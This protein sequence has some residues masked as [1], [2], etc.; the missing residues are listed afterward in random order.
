MEYKINYKRAYFKLFL[1]LLLL[2][3]SIGV[4]FY[5]KDP[6]KAGLI[7]F[8]LVVLMLVLTIPTFSVLKLT[9]IKD[10]I[11]MNVNYSDENSNYEGVNHY[12]INKINSVKKTI[13]FIIVKGSFDLTIYPY[14][15]SKR[16]HYHKDKKII[17]IPRVLNDE[18]NLIST[19][20][21]FINN[22]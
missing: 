5:L 9:I 4:I 20:S 3:I 8:F 18:S 6:Y 17:I 22:K 7:D 16:K 11:L 21:K 13:L 12:K 15:D 10:I 19:L 14:G 1:S 2:C